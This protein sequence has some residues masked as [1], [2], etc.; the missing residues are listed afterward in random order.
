MKWLKWLGA[1][2]VIL[3]FMGVVFSMELSTMNSSVVQAG[4]FSDTRT[5]VPTN[6]PEPSEWSWQTVNAVENGQWKGGQPSFYQAMYEDKDEPVNSKIWIPQWYTNDPSRTTENPVPTVNDIEPD[7]G[8]GRARWYLEKNYSPQAE[9]FEDYF[10][11]SI[12]WGEPG[13]PDRVNDNLYNWS[14][15]PNES[16]SGTLMFYN[17]YLFYSKMFR[18]R[19]VNGAWADGT[20]E[21]KTVYSDDFA[22]HWYRYEENGHPVS[23]LDLTKARLPENGIP[24]VGNKPDKHYKAEGSWEI[25]PKKEEWNNEPDTATEYGWWK[26]EDGYGEHK[27]DIITFTYTYDEM[28]KHS[29]DV[30]FKVVNGAWDNETEEEKKK[31]DKVVRLED[32]EDEPLKLKETE[33]P[34]VGSV[35][36]E[37]FAAGSWDTKPDPETEITRDTEYTYTYAPRG[38][39]SHTVTFRVVNGAWDDEKKTKEEKTVTLSRYEDEDL[40][41]VLKDSDIPAAGSN[42]DEGFTAGSWDTEPDTE[43]VITQDTTYIYTYA[44]APA[45]HVIQGEG[46]KVTQGSG[47]GLTFVTDGDFSKFT[48]IRVDGSPVDPSMYDAGS[49]STIVTLKPAYTDSLSVGSHTIDFLYADGSCTTYFEVLKKVTPT[50]TPTATPTPTPTVTPTPTPTATPTTTPTVTP[51]PTVTVTPRP[52]VTTSP[53]RPTAAPGAPA[54]TTGGTAAKTSDSSQTGLWLMLMA[55]SALG[56]ILAVVFRKRFGNS[57]Q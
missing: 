13:D 11:P 9:K 23:E 53:A 26:D 55:V 29:Q 21:D 36:D 5:I 54:S 24:A 48:G 41:L 4:D 43:T 12:F 32:Y 50:P 52:T 42:P 6:T 16:S 38:R 34:A 10:K 37:G 45:Y 7:A 44:E 30:T 1:L 17:L 19:V 28:D 57:R 31:A 40:A 3:L 46:G 15:Y 49:G 22:M 14:Y 33:I 51:T 47:K 27:N 20:K 56:L 2:S 35:P 25:T 39:V 18:F 8:Y